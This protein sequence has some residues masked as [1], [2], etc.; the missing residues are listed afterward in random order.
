MGPLMFVRQWP[1]LRFGQAD[2][3]NSL[4]VAPNLVCGN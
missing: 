3:L 1:L 4:R 2:I